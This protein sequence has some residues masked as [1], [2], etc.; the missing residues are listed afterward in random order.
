M[1]KLNKLIVCF[2]ALGLVFT[3][4]N[5]DEQETA[6]YS[7]HL[8]DAPGDYKAVKVNVIGLEVIVN[9][10]TKNLDVEAGVYDL[11]E[12]TG[13]VRALLAGGEFPAGDL[14]QI[15]L[16]LGDQNS[17]VIEGENGDE[18]YELQTPSAQQSGLKL[19]VH[20]T[21]EPGILYEFILDFNVDKSVV[22]LGDHSGYILKPVIRTTT[23]AESGAI[24]GSVTPADAQTLVTAASVT[25]TISA[26]TDEAGAYL[27][28]AVPAGNYTVTVGENITM[29]DVEVIIGETKDLGET[30][31]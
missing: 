28:Y 21:L 19:N 24:S 8:V 10:E 14:S 16:V 12:L 30:A 3:S 9:G 17:L 13:G 22:A 31:I 29:E 15:R 5:K 4:C 20:Q 27:L 18:E 25:D 23:L 11:L 6:T 2:A 7:V 1:K 26:Y